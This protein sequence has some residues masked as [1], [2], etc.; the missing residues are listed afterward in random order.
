[1]VFVGQ[2]S[3]GEHHPES[4]GSMF[5]LFTGLDRNEDGLHRVTK[6]VTQYF[7]NVTNNQQNKS[8]MATPRKPSD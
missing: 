7:T 4:R 2:F 3:G 5:F 1:M 6:V 8:E